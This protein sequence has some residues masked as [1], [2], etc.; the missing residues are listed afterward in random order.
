MNPP[1]P[2]SCLPINIAS[3][4]ILKRL[5]RCVVLQIAEGSTLALLELKLRS[6]YPEIRWITRRLDINRF[7]VELPVVHRRDFL[8]MKEIDKIQVLPPTS[9]N[10]DAGNLLNTTKCIFMASHENSGMCPTF[11]A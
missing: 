8:V 7:L 6:K 11:N 1:I 3:K 4:R 2:N 5:K 9:K 10:I